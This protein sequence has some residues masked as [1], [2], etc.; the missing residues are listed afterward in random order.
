MPLLL[1]LALCGPA[2]VWSQTAANGSL[3]TPKDSILLTV[4]NG[5]KLIHHI[6]KPK[7]TLFA[8]ARF[9]GLSLEELYAL[10]PEFQTDPVLRVG[11]LVSIPIPN[12]A[13]RRYKGKDFEPAKFAPIYYVVQQGDNLFQI[14]KRHFS[15]PVDSVKTRNNLKNESIKPGQLLHIGWMG[16]EGISSEWRT[17]AAPPTTDQAHQQ[18]YD[19]EKKNRGEVLGQGV[20]FWQKD[21]NEKGDLYALHREAIIGTVIAVTNP[22]SRRTVYAK[23][24]GRIPVGYASNI[25]VVLSAAAARQIG[26]RD[27]RF[28]VKVR[29]LR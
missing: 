20:C 6:V 23:V 11:M 8:L 25:E 24:I 17:P 13:I 15:M 12:R 29:Y 4:N 27:P 26:A 28:F 18:R 2:S 21:S 3:L 19:E 14:C 7:Q 22:M 16:L 1:I 10:H 5:Q 9:Y